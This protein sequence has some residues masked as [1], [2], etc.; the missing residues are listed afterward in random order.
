LDKIRQGGQ[1]D[2]GGISVEKA[3]EE[4]MK[5]LVKLDA[6]AINNWRTE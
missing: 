6:I 1:L 4:W 2:A 3:L 5:S